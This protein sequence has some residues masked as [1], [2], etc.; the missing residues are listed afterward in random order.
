MFTLANNFG[1]LARATPE[2]LSPSAHQRGIS[3][4]RQGSLSDEGLDYVILI[5]ERF[6][7]LGQMAA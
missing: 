7:P 4:R 1:N 6:F 3:S 2:E 5:V